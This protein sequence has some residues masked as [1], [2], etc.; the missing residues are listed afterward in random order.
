MKRRKKLRLLQ[1]VHSLRRGG[2]ERVLLE[3][4]RGALE[5]EH[6]VA[7]VALVKVHDYREAAYRGIPA[8]FLIEP[9]D[10]RWP[11]GIRRL[12]RGLRRRLG[13]IQ[14]D[15]IQ[16]HTPNALLVAACA[17]LAMPT[18]VVVHGYGE[19]DRSGS[20]AAIRRSADRWAFRRLGRRAVAVSR[21]LATIAARHFG[22]LEKEVRVIPNGIDLERFPFVDRQLP[23]SPVISLVGTLGEVKRVDFAL[24][25][26]A[27]LFERWPAPRLRVVGD[28]PERQRL[29]AMATE[30]GLDGAVDFLGQRSDVPEILADTH[31]F[32]QLSLSEGL[33]IAVLE[34]M[35]TGLPV[36]AS[37]VRGLR[38]VVRDG[39]TGYLVVQDDVEGVAVRSMR[40]LSSPREYQD[41]ARQARIRV[42]RRFSRQQMV[43][44]HLDILE[45]VR[46]GRW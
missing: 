27:Y 21:P 12:A 24:R 17:G 8:Q 42:E 2:A 41:L 14:P 28:G 40:L 11:A 16:I 44:E 9:G 45:R 26:F 30:L 29:E 15:V 36:V 39:E 5:A 18:V 37:A 1:L 33:P 32:W 25:A 13:E 34:A 43:T 3:L 23:D 38:E 35:A 7:V 46:H 19:L 31:L 6:S 20:R 4:A 22:C 10:Y